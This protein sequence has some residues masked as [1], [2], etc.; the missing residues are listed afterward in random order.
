MARGDNPIQQYIP[1]LTQA[2][3]DAINKF[4]TNYGGIKIPLEVIADCR[5]SWLQKMVF[6]FIMATDKS[7]EGHFWSNK[8]MMNMFQASQ[9]AI[10]EAYNKL[11]TIGLI[12]LSYITN[13]NRTIRVA[14]SKYKMAM[15]VKE[16]YTPRV[17]ESYRGGIKNLLANVDSKESTNNI[18]ESKDK[19]PSASPCA[20]VSEGKSASSIS[21]QRANAPRPRKNCLEPEIIS[22]REYFKKAC[23]D[24][25]GFTPR[26]E[27]KDN[28]YVRALLEDES[29]SEIKSVIDHCLS[30]PDTEWQRNHA[31]LC[32]FLTVPMFSSYRGSK[33][34]RKPNTTA[35]RLAYA[36]RTGTRAVV[37]GLVAERGKYDG[38]T[39]RMGGNQD[40][41]R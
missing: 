17:K 10:T 12:E 40:G 13:N 28:K 14:K 19:T 30:A 27:G 41:A 24:K 4:P 23:K 26:V 16:S 20:V 22:I 39:K 1:E 37:D 31:S 21:K 35:E 9:P 32:G 34:G 18:K 2:T 8:L 6:G 7:D 5:L 36:K 15:V 25:L 38:L 11:E 33:S 29:E 3:I